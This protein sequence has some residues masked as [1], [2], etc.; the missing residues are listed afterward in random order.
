M[1]NP[2]YV[3]SY[4]NTHKVKFGGHTMSPWTGYSLELIQT[5]YGRISADRFRGYQDDVVNL[6]YTPSAECTFNG[7]NNVQ[8]V[9]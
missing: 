6:S 4:P 7:W 1:K 2:K 5:N 3:V 9:Y 8:C